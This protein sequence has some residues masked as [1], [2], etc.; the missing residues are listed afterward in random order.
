MF[1]DFD[2][3]RGFRVMIKTGKTDPLTKGRNHT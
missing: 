1:E 3:L 2:K